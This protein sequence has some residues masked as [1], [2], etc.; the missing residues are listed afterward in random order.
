MFSVLE[1]A[2][3]GVVVVDAA[4]ATIYMNASARSVF[5]TDGAL[6]MWTAT[7]LDPM[8]RN[9]RHATHAIERWTHDDLI[10]RIRAR[11][12]EPA[13]DLIALEITLVQA[14]GRRVA[15]QLCRGLRLS[16]TDAKL[17]TL[18]WRGLSNDDIAVELGIRVG[19]V[20]SRLFR[21]YQKLG[22]KR[23]AAAVLRAAEVLA[24]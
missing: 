2:E 24:A 20:K 9:L 5:E 14:G 10:L 11:P 18:V 23:R 17:L 16:F 6:P 19:T 7:F 12:L 13:S 8:L 1:H 3:I 22:V 4:G 21:L 15:D